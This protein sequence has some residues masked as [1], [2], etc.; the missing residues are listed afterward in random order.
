V[1]HLLEAAIALN[2]Y[3]GQFPEVDGLSSVSRRR[4]GGPMRK[5]ANV[6]GQVGGKAL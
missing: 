1:G 5:A 6:P 3:R 2:H 4:P